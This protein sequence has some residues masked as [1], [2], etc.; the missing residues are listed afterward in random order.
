MSINE[1]WLNERHV[2][3]N[4]QDIKIYQQLQTNSTKYTESTD[5]EEQMNQ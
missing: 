3:K 5:M 4:N 2:E 1:S